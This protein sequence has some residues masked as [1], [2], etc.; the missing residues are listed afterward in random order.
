MHKLAVFVEGQTELL[1]AWHLIEQLCATIRITVQLA[2]IVGRRGSTELVLLELREATGGS[3]H[4]VL[5]V[6]CG[7]D[8]RVKT[9]ILDRYDGLVQQGF[10]RILAIRDV[11]PAFTYNEVPRLRAGLASGLPS[12]SVEIVFILGVMEVEAWFLAEH[13][14]YPRIHSAL[15]VARIKAELGIDVLIDDLEQRPTPSVDLVNIYWLE[16]MIYDKSRERVERT[17]RALDMTNLQTSVSQRFADLR[18]LLAEVG[19][20][21]VRPDDSR[22]DP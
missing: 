8:E 5:L 1:F 14:H 16:L 11:A 2:N 18:R 19:D 22:S 3:S 21:C 9:A 17:V 20:L 6:D 12:G 7:S 15:T 10:T 13:L 4:F